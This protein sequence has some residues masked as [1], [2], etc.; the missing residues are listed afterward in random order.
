MLLNKYVVFWWSDQ[1]INT[2]YNYKYFA[3]NSDLK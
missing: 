1:F 2:K 3:V